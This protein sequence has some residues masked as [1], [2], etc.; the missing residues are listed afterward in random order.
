M[1]RAK[2]L[3]SQTG[4]K[5]K[6]TT[7]KVVTNLASLNH[8]NLVASEEL[9]DQGVSVLRAYGIGPCG[10]PGFYGTQDVH[11][12]TE[13]DIASHLGVP[14]AILY[15]QSF[16]TISSVIPNFSKRGDIIV[17]DRA[18][19]YPIRKGMQISRS[20]VY[21]YEHNDMADLE[22]VLQKVIREQRGKKLT[23]RFIVTEAV[24]E[25][26]GDILDL[27]AIVRFKHQ[28]KFRIILDESLSYGV[29]GSRGAGLTDAAG[30]DPNEI[31][32]ICGSLSGPL[33]GGGG[34][35]AGDTDVVEH[36]RI[37]SLSYTFSAALPAILAVTASQTIAIM[38]MEDGAQL[39]ATLREN[40]QALRDQLE[41]RSN[42]VRCSS[43][44]ENPIQL[45][46]FKDE[47]IKAR[48]WSRVEQEMVMAD[49]VDECLA[50]NVFVT[51]LKAMPVEL[52]ISP[53]A[54]TWQPQPAIKVCLTTG[55]TRKEVEKAAIEIRHAI[56]KVVSKKK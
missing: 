11:M 23:R 5:V 9:K 2:L 31:D 25:N 44:P 17:A 6:L 28:Y 8:Y 4:P 18:V 34:F 47:V 53:R 48:G 30:I 43:A 54:E 41:P 46:V 32:M 42:F 36:Q 16:S 37:T 40:I 10:P 22:R 56:T 35:C 1:S 55:L 50:K 39:R 12:R 15:A 27:A 49:I 21:W 29:L 19:N 38:Q 14:A 7:G 24:S 20:T 51:R 13:A 26:V 3:R 52:G 33:I 45:L